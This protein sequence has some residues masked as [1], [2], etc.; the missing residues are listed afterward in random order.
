[1]QYLPAICLLVLYA[2]AALAATKRFTLSLGYKN[3]A[4]DGFPM[5]MMLANG[6]IDYPI[7]VNKVTTFDTRNAA[8]HLKPSFKREQGDNVVVTV[9]NNLNVS[10]AIHWHGMYQKGTPWM[11][12]ASMV[13]QCPIHPGDTYIY[14]F[15][16]GN[17]TGTYWWHAHH[18]SQYVNG[19][20]G[21]FIIKDP[22]DPYLR[23]YDYDITMTLSD[24]Y[25]AGSE[26]LLKNFFDASNVNAFEPLPDSGLIGG[27]GQYN[28]SVVPKIKS[29]KSNSPL[30]TYSV[31]PGKRYRVRL[32]NTAAQAHY[33]FSI[34]GHNMTVIEADGSY[35]NPTVVDEISIHSAQRYSFI[36]TAKAKTSNY[37]IRA[38]MVD[39]WGLDT[40]PNGLNMDVRAIL[41]YSGAVVGTPKTVKQNTS[42][43][44]DPW[45]LGELN[46]LT[47]ADVPDF[48]SYNQSLYFTFFYGPPA[49]SYPNATVS[50]KSDTQNFQNATYKMPVVGKEAP[51][52]STLI[53]NKTSQF[54]SSINPIYVHNNQW[55]Y[56]MIQN[57]DAMEHPFHLHGHSFY[58]TSYGSIRHQTI[59]PTTYAKRDTIQVP[60]C[61]GGFGQGGELG[62]LKGYV[63][64]AIKFDNPGAWL[65]HCHIEW[66]MAAGMMMTFINNADDGKDPLPNLSKN[67]A[68]V[69]WWA[70]DTC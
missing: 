55:V 5:D 49:Y 27:A 20:R 44:L 34:D 58:I 51:T 65:F 48:W 61:T 29:C 14:S 43:P 42:M 11:D 15:N 30:K 6:Q 18:Q 7:T 35:T 64:L 38:K 46:G 21:P 10:T 2:A 16:V 28:C 54:P 37:W 59:P 31:I 40:F 24:Y 60:A 22:Q 70:F 25:H 68:A 66:H 39:T 19:L 36:F 52:L 1:M 69:P 32:I 67:P 12:G 9:V 4:P 8:A 17:Q 56:M 53:H 41:S 23:Q 33:L 62:C 45:L 13:T 26:Y 57:A 63:T 47:E 3:M 50:I